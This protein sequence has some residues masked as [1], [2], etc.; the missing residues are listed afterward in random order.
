M[1]SS[2]DNPQLQQNQQQAQLQASIQQQQQ[3]MPQ[4]NML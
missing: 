4:A 3:R 2:T 1:G